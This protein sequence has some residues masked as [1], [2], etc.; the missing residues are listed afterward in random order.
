MSRTNRNLAVKA[1]K[2]K[3]QRMEWAYGERAKEAARAIPMSDQT[4]LIAALAS[5]DDVVSVA[6]RAVRVVKAG[7]CGRNVAKRQPEILVPSI[8]AAHW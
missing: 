6:G 4:R 8:I 7:V 3:G 5:R 2:A 1:D